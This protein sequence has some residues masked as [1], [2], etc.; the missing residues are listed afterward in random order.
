MG[1]RFTAADS[2]GSLSLGSDGRTLT[3]TAVRFVAGRSRTERVITL[4]N[5][6]DPTEPQ[7]VGE[8]L[9]Q[10]TDVIDTTLISPDGRL[11]AATENET[12]QLADISDPRHPERLGEPITHVLPAIPFDY[13]PDSRNLLTVG[14]DGSLNRWDV[15]DP[16]HPVKTVSLTQSDG[17]SWNATLAPDDRHVASA[18]SD[19]TVHLWNLDENAAIDRICAITGDMWTEELWKHRLP[20]LPYS[21]P[22]R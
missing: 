21:P 7:R 10:P 12:V 5:L 14:V 1:T 2:T 16:A 22:C 15:S 20:Q 4:W 8:L 3:V 18:S 19:G 17:Y 9:R 13:T 6:A 11:L